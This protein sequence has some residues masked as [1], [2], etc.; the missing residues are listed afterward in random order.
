MEF[1]LYGH[2]NQQNTVYVLLGRG[3]NPGP[4]ALKANAL[5]IELTLPNVALFVLCAAWFDSVCELFGET[6]RNIVGVVLI[7]LFN[8][9]E[10]GCCFSVGYIR[11]GLPTNVCVLCM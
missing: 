11:Y 7:L 10:C 1:I 4:S 8:V 3:S 6:I 5:S 2:S 9:V